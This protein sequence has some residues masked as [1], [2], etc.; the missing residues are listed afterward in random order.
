MNSPIVNDTFRFVK[1]LYAEFL[2]V[3][4]RDFQLDLAMDLKNNCVTKGLQYGMP[5]QQLEVLSL[6]ALLHNVGCIEGQYHSRDVSKIIARNFLEEKGYYDWDIQKVEHTIDATSEYASFTDDCGKII[7][8]LK[9]KQMYEVAG[10]DLYPEE[11]GDV[12]P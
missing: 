12:F 4:Y 8:T 6:A 11:M 7:Q 2:P 9:F 1:W 5:D 3:G 10:S